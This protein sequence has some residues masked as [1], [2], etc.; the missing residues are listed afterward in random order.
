MPDAPPG[1]VA[2]HPAVVVPELLRV[3]VRQPGPVGVVA[4]AD[5]VVGVGHV[6]DRRAVG[7]AQQAG[8]LVVPR[9]VGPLPVRR[10]E[11]RPRGR[12]RAA[13]RPVVV[14]LRA[15]RPAQLV[16]QGRLVQ[17]RGHDRRPPQPPAVVDAA[18]R[19]SRA[20][21]RKRL[22]RAV[23]VVH[24]QP[25]LLE[26]VLALGLPGRLSGLLDGR[27]QEGHQDGDDGDDHQQLDQ[28][29]ALADKGLRHWAA[30]LN[31]G[32]EREGGGGEERTGEAKTCPGR[33]PR[34]WRGRTWMRALYRAPAA[35]QT[36]LRT[37]RAPPRRRSPG[38][39]AKK[40][41]GR[42]CGRGVG[43]T[44]A[45]SRSVVRSRRQNPSSTASPPARVPRAPQTP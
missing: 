14:H 12:P 20:G 10:A 3:V 24:G 17:V 13:V 19:R 35:V 39:R 21:R 9:R 2:E 33:A 38:P 23:V 4:P 5:A 30:G 28:R 6:R 41:R 1:A 16:P 25:E 34:E 44:S 27:Q 45:G 32:G 29:K 37:R 7:G 22:M 36:G 15:Q 11:R 43:N 40:P 18:G 8:R 26:V 42:T 31:H